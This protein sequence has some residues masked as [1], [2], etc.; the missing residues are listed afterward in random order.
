MSHPV[1]GWL[2]FFCKTMQG[3]LIEN[4]AVPQPHRLNFFPKNL[5][6]KKLKL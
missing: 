5:P 2:I 6:Y 4:G 1:F 3:I